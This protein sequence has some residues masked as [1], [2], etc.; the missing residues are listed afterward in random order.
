MTITATPSRFLSIASWALLLPGCFADA[1]IP[2]DESA[3]SADAGAT[4]SETAIVP[5]APAGDFDY[6]IEPLCLDILP[7]L[8]LE[9]RELV[10]AADLSGTV[11]NAEGWRERTFTVDV[12][13]GV[14]AARLTGVLVEGHPENGCTSGPDDG[15][16]GCDQEQEQESLRVDCD[17]LPAFFVYA[18]RG[19]PIEECTRREGE[20][21]SISP[22]PLSCTVL[23]T[24]DGSDPGSVSFALDFEY[25]SLPP[26][27]HGENVELI[28]RTLEFPAAGQE[29]AW[30]Q[31]H[32]GLYNLERRNGHQQA[33]R[34]QR[35]NALRL[36]A[37]DILCT[38]DLSI[39]RTAMYYDDSFLLTANEGLFI[40]WPTFT[41]S[42]APHPSAPDMPYYQWGPIRG[43]IPHH[44][45]ETYCYGAPAECELVGTESVGEIAYRSSPQLFAPL[46]ESIQE[47]GYLNIQQVTTG[48][49][50]PTDCQHAPF[51]VNV[52]ATVAHPE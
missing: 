18:D 40:S 14:S 17:G 27:C 38:L 23:S 50:D 31:L 9:D 13:A 25:R 48:D 45:P 29:C 4:S 15:G 19:A 10:G 1:S 20:W 21:Q 36:G 2:G 24:S 16:R 22:G 46:Y 52:S 7:R 12:P 3:Y 8:A 30:G 11:W 47:R 42:F 28:E 37:G 32:N 26:E 43:R 33:R 49:N 5:S 51:V 39:P 6:E 34:E 44:T 35:R 41:D